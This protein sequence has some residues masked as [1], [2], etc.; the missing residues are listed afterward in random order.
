MFEWAFKVQHVKN[1]KNLDDPEFPG[2]Q[3]VYPL[4]VYYSKN[5]RYVF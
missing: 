2:P 4:S 1:K 5:E 3:D